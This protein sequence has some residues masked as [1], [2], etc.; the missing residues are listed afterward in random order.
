MR[1]VD[2]Q[3]VVAAQL[4]VPLQLGEQ[5]AIGHDAQQR[6]GGDAIG[7]PDGVADACAERRAELLGDALRDRAGGDA[8]RLGVADEALHAAAE[9]ET[10]LRQLRA[11]PRAGLA[12]DDDDLVVADGRQQLV[13]AGRDRQRLGIPQVPTLDER[14]PRRLAGIH[15]PGR[16]THAARPYRRHTI[17]ARWFS[18]SRTSAPRCGFEKLRAQICGASR[19]S[20][21]ADGVGGVQAGGSDRR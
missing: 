7:E 6:A 13:A 21:R 3:R 4:P 15:S 20:G 19:R 14:H 11:L 2:D 8:A 17:W 5:D 10:H 1:L 9:L 18:D 12:G 16:T